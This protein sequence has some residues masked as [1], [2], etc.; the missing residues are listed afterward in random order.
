[1]MRLREAY[2]NGERQRTYNG[3]SGNKEDLT[4]EQFKLRAWN[5]AADK[6]WSSSLT[7]QVVT[8]TTPEQKKSEARGKMFLSENTSGRAREY[9]ENWMLDPKVSVK[10]IWDM[11]IDT[12]AEE[13]V[14]DLESLDKEINDLAKLGPQDNDPILWYKSLEIKNNKIEKAGGDKRSDLSMHLLMIDGI[15]NHRWY[16]KMYNDNFIRPDSDQYDPVKMKEVYCKAWKRNQDNFT[17]RKPNYALYATNNRYNSTM[18][19]MVKKE[20][21]V[22]SKIKGYQYPK[23]S[24]YGC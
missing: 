9:V 2:P 19:N 24:C 18:H 16:G 4:F 13:K 22:T 1:M 15:K 5:K 23:K 6:S 20:P 17:S 12:F 11:L 8:A 10:E 14:D 3:L 7:Q 21:N